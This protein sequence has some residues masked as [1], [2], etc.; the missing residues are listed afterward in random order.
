LLAIPKPPRYD[1]NGLGDAI[2]KS[3]INKGRGDRRYS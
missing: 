1:L 3:H 2:H